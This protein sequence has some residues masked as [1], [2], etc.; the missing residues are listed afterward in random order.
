MTN[1]VIDGIVTVTEPIILQV[2]SFDVYELVEEH[3]EELFAE[4]LQQLFVE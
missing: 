4:E 2:D 3:S 1:P